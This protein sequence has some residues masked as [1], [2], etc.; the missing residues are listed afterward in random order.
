M[1]LDSVGY[2][3]PAGCLHAAMHPLHHR[4]R[5]HA[6]GPR[7]GLLLAAIKL[8]R[9]IRFGGAGF[10]PVPVGAQ[11]ASGHEHREQ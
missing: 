9:V 8:N 7:V 1:A 4:L 11:K 10:F 5:H 3:L 6:I 2:L